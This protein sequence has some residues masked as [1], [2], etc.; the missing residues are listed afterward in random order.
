MELS[1]GGWSAFW[2]AAKFDAAEIFEQSGGGGVAERR[3]F[4]QRARHDGGERAGNILE[5]GGI[6][7]DDFG[8]GGGEAFAAER[9]IA[10]EHFVED[11]AEEKRS[12]RP[13][14]GC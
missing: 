13:S 9:L 10:A 7:V 14:S 2:L 6:D 12:E 3:D 5:R 11:E 1:G 8:Y 4:G